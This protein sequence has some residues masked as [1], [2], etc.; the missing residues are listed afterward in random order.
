MFASVC[1]SSGV[2]ATAKLFVLGIIGDGSLH[3]NMG[4]YFFKSR[5]Q[6]CCFNFLNNTMLISLWR[7]SEK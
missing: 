7:V 2:P 1:E 6:S 3:S 4:R 5:S